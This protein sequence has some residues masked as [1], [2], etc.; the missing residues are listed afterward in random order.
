MHNNTPAFNVSITFGARVTMQWVVRAANAQAAEA[1]VLR[2]AMHDVNVTALVKRA[3]V[4]DVAQ[5]TTHANAIAASD[6][7]ALRKKYYIAM[8]DITDAP[9][10]YAVCA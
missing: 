10:M 2:V 3:G 9:M 1:A 6:E 4:A 8:T 7:K 5:A